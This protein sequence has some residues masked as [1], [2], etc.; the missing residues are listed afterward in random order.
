MPDTAKYLINARISADGVVERNDVVGAVFG[1]TEGLLGDDL[2]LRDLQES[3][4]VGRIDVG[5]DSEGGQSFGHLTIATSLDKVETA[6]LAAGL[7]TIDRVGPCRADLEVTGIEDVRAAKRREVVDR[8][9]ELL[10]EAF[11]GRGGPALHP[12]RGH[13]RVRGAPRRPERR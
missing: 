10:A 8:A 4:K 13:G 1:Q 11:Q 7:E 6:I 12:R 9:K 2:D 3:S 5:I